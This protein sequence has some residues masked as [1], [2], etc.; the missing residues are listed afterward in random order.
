MAY[1]G[2][3]ELTKK[4]PPKVDNDNRAWSDLY[5][6]LNHLIDSVNSKSTTEQRRPGDLHNSIG[7]LKVFKDKTDN[8]YYMETMTEDG[9]ARREMFIS[10]KD[11]RSGDDFYSLAGKKSGGGGLSGSKDSRNIEQQLF[12]QIPWTGGIPNN[13]TVDADGKLVTDTVAGATVSNNYIVQA[14]LVGSDKTWTVKPNN[15][16]I[17]SDGKIVEDNV[18]GAIVTNNKIVAADVVGSGKTFTTKPPVTFR[19]ASI[20]TALTAGDL[21]YDTDDGNKLY[22][23]DAAGADQITSGEWIATVDATIAIAQA[24]A[25]TA[26]GKAVAAQNTANSAL[27]TANGKNISFYQNEAPTA[28]ATGDMWFDTNDEYKMYRWGGSAW[29][30]VNAVP[31][32]SA[33]V[34]NA[35]QINAGTISSGRIATSSLTAANINASQINAGTISADRIATSSLTAATITADA[36]NMDTATISG[37]LEAGNINVSGVVTTESVNATTITADAINMD[38]ATVSGTLAAGNIDVSGVVS[39]ESVNAVGISASSISTGTLSA[40]E[41]NMS[42]GSAQIE[43]SGKITTKNLVKCFSTDVGGSRMGLRLIEHGDTS[44]ADS[45]S[46]NWW[47]LFVD[48]D[49]LIFNKGGY[50]KVTFDDDGKIEAN[51]GANEF[52]PNHTRMRLESSDTGSDRW[53]EIYNTDTEVSTNHN[54]GGLRWYSND[55]SNSSEHQGW[56]CSIG[57]VN[58]YDGRMGLTFRHGGV[59][60]ADDFYT[61][62]VYDGDVINGTNTTVW[63]QTSDERVKENIVEVD[64]A[65]S[66]VTALR[67]VTFNF[68]SDY[69]EESGHKDNKRWGFLGQE[70]KTAIPEGVTTSADYGYEDFHKLNSDMLVPLLV[71]AVK[72]LKAEV[73]ALKA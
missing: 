41:I 37:T 36:I 65:L 62:F 51:A 67:P 38:T 27:S 46:T 23:A 42:S 18:A 32:L 16:T 6:T 20:P 56:V 64:D 21:W 69:C 40:A 12:E 15:T 31:T 47:Q 57:G 61:K 4:K 52:T 28:L 3:I 59:G 55:S 1:I 50:N 19:Q 66:V 68:N 30:L 14:D 73:D 5:D 49:D 29:N 7:D 53:Y 10:D 63:Q 70:F 39:A 54:I 71:K 17:D 43:T 72:E 2:Q 48:S 58:Y 22:R 44:S 11:S 34:I 13:I 45:G 25:D 33:I 35:S 26:D 8:K 60:S 24:D 9:S